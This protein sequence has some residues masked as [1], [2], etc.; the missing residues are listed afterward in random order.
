MLKMVHDSFFTLTR[1]AASPLRSAPALQES[2]S[3]VGLDHVRETDSLHREDRSSRV[4][5]FATFVGRE[6]APCCAVLPSETRF[7][8]R[9]E[10][11]A[12]LDVP[13]H[14]V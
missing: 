14:V 2:G 1:T 6:V 4:G 5:K 11:L 3:P 12:V 10:I 8:Q 13:L 7:A 9:R